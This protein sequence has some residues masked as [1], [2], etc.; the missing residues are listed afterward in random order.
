MAAVEAKAQ[1]VP[2]WAGS[3]RPRPGA[4]RQQARRC[5]FHAVNWREPAIRTTTPTAIGTARASAGCCISIAASAT[6]SG[7]AAIPNTVHRRLEHGRHCEK[8]CRGLTFF[9][10]HVILIGMVP[11]KSRL[12]ISTPQ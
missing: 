3:V 7:K 2:A 6:P 1:A 5:A 4:S 9:M 8:Q 10:S 12:P 11:R